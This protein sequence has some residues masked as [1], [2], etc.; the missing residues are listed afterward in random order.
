[1]H[2]LKSLYNSPFKD[3][4]SHHIHTRFVMIA[5]NALGCA[6]HAKLCTVQ[7]Q[8]RT[9]TDILFVYASY[10]YWKM[11][12]YQKGTLLAFSLQVKMSNNH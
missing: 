11:D 4:Y 2:Q 3:S 7:L 1:M 6:V 10:V 5:S 12:T 8:G 9:K